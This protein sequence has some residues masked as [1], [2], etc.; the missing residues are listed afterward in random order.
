[1]KFKVL[2]TETNE[3]CNLQSTHPFQINKELLPKKN[4]LLGQSENYRKFPKVK[5]I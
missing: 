1:M 4:Y 5:I 3:L 2:F